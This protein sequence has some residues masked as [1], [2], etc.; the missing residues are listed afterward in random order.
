MA[1]HEALTWSVKSNTQST[2]SM[3]NAVTGYHYSM[4]GDCHLFDIS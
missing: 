2:L 1:Q 4:M 3:L